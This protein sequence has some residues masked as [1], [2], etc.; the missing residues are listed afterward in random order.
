MCTVTF[1]ARRN[2]YALGM[3][4]DEMLARVKAL[5]P[6][7]S[8]I[9]G[10]FAIYPSEPSGGTWIGVND[11]GVTFALINWYSVPAKLAG[12]PISRGEVVKLALQCH[13]APFVHTQLAEFPLKLINPFR[14]IGVFPTSRKVVEWRWNLRALERIDHA[15]E[16]NTWI[17]SGFD[18]A[19][20]QQTR[21]KIFSEALRRPAAGS[22]NWLRR[23]HRSHAPERGAYSHCMHRDEAATMSYTEVIVSEAA[24]TMRYTP[25]APCCGGP[26]SGFRLELTGYMDADK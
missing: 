1:I 13:S 23:L 24:A 6:A 26:A 16:T 15:W 19:G 11:A 18:E 20:A 14:L 7:R 3:N 22:V 10:R 2:G 25:G 12:P 17:S 8:L 4:R 9:H 21:G 5:P